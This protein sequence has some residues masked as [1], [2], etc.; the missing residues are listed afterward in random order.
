MEPQ[1]IVDNFIQQMEQACKDTWK[2]TLPIYNTICKQKFIEVSNSYLK[3]VRKDVLP[4]R[5]KICHIDKKIIETLLQAI[6]TNQPVDNFSIYH[7]REY[8]GEESDVI[9]TTINDE[10]Y[11]IF[12][13]IGTEGAGCRLQYNISKNNLLEVLNQVMTFLN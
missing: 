1:Q 12:N 6:N 5:M 10:E 8:R 7:I 9:I 4:I 3:H 11:L 13:D 2:V